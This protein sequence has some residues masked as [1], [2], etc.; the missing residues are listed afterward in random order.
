[1]K[2]KLITVLFLTA[3]MFFTPSIT[4]AQQYGQG[5]ILSKGGETEIVHEPVE[6]GLKEDLAAIGI[7]LI[8]SSLTLS[9]FSLKEKEKAG[10]LN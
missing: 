7:L 5:V 3:L 6:A 2:N 1:M 9:Y 8:L 4:N 10:I